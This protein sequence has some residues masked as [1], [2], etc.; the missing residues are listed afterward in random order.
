MLILNSSNNKIG[1]E[2]YVLALRNF[3]PIGHIKLTPNIETSIFSYISLVYVCIIYQGNVFLYVITCQVSSNFYI[4][5]PITLN[6]SIF[7]DQNREY[8]FLQTNKQTFRD[9]H[10]SHVHS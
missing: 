10:K 9:L 5:I 3:K 7:S 1:A 6:E 2:T 8:L 4:S